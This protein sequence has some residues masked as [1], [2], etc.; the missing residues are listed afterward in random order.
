MAYEEHDFVKPQR[1]VDTALAALED[2]LIVPNLFHK[3]GIDNY[4][5]SDDD[6][7]HVKVEGV[8]PYRTYGWRNDR[9]TPVQFDRY[10]ERKVPV[11]FGGDLI[12]GV[13]LTDEQALMDTTGWD[14]LAIK[15]IEAI[16]R[17]LED[18]A[19][20]AL[21]DA[22]Y[23]VVVTLDEADMRGSL[24]RLKSVYDRLRVK[25][26]RRLI[27]GS[28]V[29]AAI[30]L[31]DKITLSQN[32]SEAVAEQ[33]LREAVI[34]RVAGFNLVSSVEMPNTEAVAMVESGFVITTAA[35]AVPRSIAHG[36]TGS[37]GGFAVRWMTD[38]DADFQVDRSIFR[39]FKGFRYVD[40]PL[41]GKDAV[42]G[43]AFVSEDLHFVRAIKV[44]LGDA[45]GVEVSN[46]ELADITGIKDILPGEPEDEEL[47]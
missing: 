16:T 42:T 36:A 17:G 27:L 35:P 39:M 4:K 30:L 32:S 8:L 31:D 22:P 1:I 28:D 37:A 5:G 6:T 19:V 13:E 24:V 7:Y 9:S 14:K 23:E 45:F 10:T 38:Y 18:G 12:S 43:Q 33:A 20:E 40:D 41:L 44:E 15:Q 29:E 46:T 2:T 11:T 3:E 26:S 34:G 47:P 21:L 25:G